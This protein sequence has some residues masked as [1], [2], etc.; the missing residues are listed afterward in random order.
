MG[1]WSRLKG[2]MGGDGPPGAGADAAEA[3]GDPIA[4]FWAFWADNA[5][6][7]ARA[8]DDGTLG[9][10]TARISELV[11]AVHPDL[12]W[13]FGAG[14]ASQHYFCVSAEGN[15]ELRIE[16]ERWLVRAPLR[17]A[18]WEFHAAKPGGS[19]SGFRLELDGLTLDADEVRLGVERDTA[20]L[21][22]HVQVFH[23]ALVGAE[24][25]ARTFAAFLLL[26]TVLG[27]DDV[28]RWLGAIDVAETEPAESIGLAELPAL[29]EGLA[30]EGASHTFFRM[31]HEDG[32]EL[33]AVV[34]VAVKRIDHLLLDH[35]IEIH[36]QL[37]PREDGM[38]DADENDLLN[39]AEDA[40]LE[41]LGH[42]A[43]FIAHETG[44]GLR[45]I[46]LHAS[47]LGPVPAI[48]DAWRREHGQYAIEVETRRDPTWDVLGRW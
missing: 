22:A 14:R 36:I 13:E 38:L 7:L 9:D 3:G 8:I 37:P 32:R 18:T 28:E 6:A 29:V 31:Q 12:A 43:V 48:V 27:E 19:A 11:D 42:D 45:T 39:E 44:L 34:N 16:A 47:A 20:R 21:R 2:A 1:L 46:Y 30:A 5:D 41:R 40:L 35:L 15:I 24:D 26:D 10:W 25:S 17:D 4:R 23:P 33:L